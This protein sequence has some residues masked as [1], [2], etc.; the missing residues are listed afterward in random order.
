MENP[1]QM[2]DLGAYHH[3]RNSPYCQ[4]GKFYGNFLGPK[5]QWDCPVSKLTSVI[6][7]KQEETRF[8]TGCSRVHGLVKSSLILIDSY[9]MNSTICAKD[10]FRWIRKIDR[11]TDRTPAIAG[12]DPATEQPQ[13]WNQWSSTWILSPFQNQSGIGKT[14]ENY[15]LEVS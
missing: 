8:Q 3:F 15:I 11:F 9:W 14:W 6:S 12:L 13:I 2:D 4:P 7:E 10:V 5:R 1:I